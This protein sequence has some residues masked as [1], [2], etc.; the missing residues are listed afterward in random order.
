MNSSLNTISFHPLRNSA[1]W[2]DSKDLSQLSRIKEHQL[3][4]ILV[5]D[6]VARYLGMK[7]GDVVKIIRKSETAGKYVT[8]RIAI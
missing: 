4:K 6:P 7:R 5:S 3:P 2:N 8:Y 1:Y